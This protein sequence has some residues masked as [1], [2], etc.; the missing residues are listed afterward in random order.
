MT[1]PNRPTNS[2]AAAARKIIADRP[3]DG[4]LQDA[5]NSLEVGFAVFDA[6]LRLLHCNHAYRALWPGMEAL[7][8]EGTSF[9]ELCTAI[10]EGHLIQLGDMK[11]KG[12]IEQRLA[13]IEAGDG[14]SEILLADGRWIEA[15]DRYMEGGGFVCLCRETTTRQSVH[16]QLR[17]SEM[18][19]RA[20][21]EGSIQ[22]I[23]V[24]R[25]YQ[26]LFANQE[27][28][29]IFG[30][31][32]VD[33]LMALDSVLAL[34]A[35]EERSR[36]M[37]HKVARTQGKPAPSVYDMTGLRK[38]GSR[39][40]VESR[41]TTIDWD[42]QPAILGT[43]IDI[44]Q[45]HEALRSLAEREEVF[46]AFFE[47]NPAAV[48]IKGLD[49]TFQRVNRQ[50]E[51]WFGISTEVAAGKSS[52]ELFPR[53]PATDFIDQDRETLET[54]GVTRREMEVIFK[55]QT[56]HTL[57]SIKFPVRNPDG[58]A[59]GLGTISTDIS[60]QKRA[61]EALRESEVRLRIIM[62]NSPLLISL[63]SV[64][65]RY[66]MV[67]RSFA[68]HCGRSVEEIIG[69]SA[70][71]IWGNDPGTALEEIDAKV[72]ETGEM[73]EEDREIVNPQGEAFN[74]LNIKF[75]LPDNDGNP[76]MIGTISVDITERKQYVD[77]LLK[78]K[79][80]A[81]F[82]NRA[83]TE[84]LANMSHELRTPL[85]SIIGFS[86]ILR[87]ELFGAHQVVQYKE[88][89]ENIN[90]SGMHLLQLISDILDVSKIEAG[91]VALEES[92]VDLRLLF[93]ECEKMVAERSM[94]AGVTIISQVAMMTNELYGD[95]LRLKQ[96][97]L[98][99]LTNAIKF[100]PPTGEISL[101]AEMDLARQISIIVADNGIGISAE[102]IHR[103][104]EPFYQAATPKIHLSD[105]TGLG[106][107]LAA[108]LAS[109]H[110]AKLTIESDG[111]RGTTV[112]I[113][114]PIERTI[115]SS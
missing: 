24:H 77:Q 81:E 111:V 63:K 70:L 91:E 11:A 26:L 72:I 96:I 105:G 37:R 83:K 88:Y 60:V 2:E 25:D 3:L 19:F 113:G 9:A 41:V 82:A 39:L 46:A 21:V 13:N 7:L 86:E 85:N 14:V 40:Q 33:E 17:E 68:E 78:S 48:H 23:I 101:R 47:N 27:M 112:T 109:L 75:A 93:D 100:T 4:I 15:T 69:K 5:L 103:V 16:K 53:T 29:E 51:E 61:E 49:G 95:P 43:A 10:A 31:N 64:D 94:R 102:D 6:D 12:W 115:Q 80:E 73:L 45:R 32:S 1:T 99:L 110:G 71:E 58:T 36:L 52:D 114:F 8:V 18:R 59:I 35:P 55:D 42:G 38:D 44:T 76:S 108:E 56:Q 104:T 28:A 30:Y 79:E 54:D 50:F 90:A 84:F 22:G 89:A 66:L 57:T 106:L 20:V 97:I 34:F 65:G 87:E 74:F 107:T 67:N 98:N 62:D 92:D